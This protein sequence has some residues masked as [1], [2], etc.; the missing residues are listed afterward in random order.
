MT[1]RYL[2]RLRPRSLTHTRSV[3]R[4]SG[5]VQT[6]FLAL[7]V[8]R[9]FRASYAGRMMFVPRRCDRWNGQ[10]EARILKS[11]GIVTGQ[12]SSPQPAISKL[13]VDFLCSFAAVA[14]EHQH[15]MA[16]INSE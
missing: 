12:I 7:L 9:R 16:V 14:A 13:C 2:H 1:L 11:A 5:F 15:K 4:A 8:R 10:R 6:H 3:R